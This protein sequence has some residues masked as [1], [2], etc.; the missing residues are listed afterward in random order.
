[1][2]TYDT[3]Q[4]SQI[5][6][7]TSSHG[8]DRICGVSI[9]RVKQAIADTLKSAKRQ[10]LAGMPLVGFI[11]PDPSSP[12]FSIR[13]ITELEGNT[14]LRN[15]SEVISSWFP[16]GT[17][18]CPSAMHCVPFSME[19]IPSRR[20]FFWE[21]SASIENQESRRFL[22][23]HAAT[24]QQEV[25]LALKRP[26]FAPHLITTRELS[27]E[28]HALRLRQELIRK[29]INDKRHSPPELLDELHYFLLS[30]NTS[31]KELRTT[32]HLL[33]LVRSHY[34]LRQRQA[35]LPPH[36]PE[37]KKV[38][39]RLF[40]SELH[41]PFG[42]RRVL[43]LVISVNSLLPHE[44]F[45]DRHILTACQRCLASLE[46]IPNSFYC[47]R[48]SENSYHAL[49]VEV[50]KQNGSWFTLRELKTL[51]RDLEKRFSSSIEQVVN[52]IDIPQN[53][54]DTIRS[55]LLLSQQLRSFKDPPQVMIQF[56]GQ[57]DQ[58][59]EFQVLLMRFLKE[60][61]PEI[62]VI[63]KLPEMIRII[64]LRASVVGKLRNKYTKQALTLLARC[65]KGPFHRHDRSIDFLKAREFVVNC[66]EATLGKVR[67][68][69]GGLFLQQHELLEGIRPLLMDHE[70]KELF[71]VEELFHSI[72]PSIM[73]SVV[74]PEHILTIFRQ[75][76][77][78]RNNLKKGTN[79]YFV[80]EE[81]AKGAFIGFISPE[82]FAIE[83]ILQVRSILQISESDLAVCQCISEGQS[84]SFVVCLS[85]DRRLQT[86]LVEWVRNTLDERKKQSRAPRSLRIS[87]PNISFPLDPRIGPDNSSGSVIKML[88]EGLYRLDPT[89]KPSLAIAE[90]VTVSED[91]KTYTFFLRPTYWSNGKPVT[92]H[93]FEYGWKKFNTPSFVT[94]Y[95]FLFHPIK[96]AKQVKNGELPIEALGVR[97]VSDHILVV[98]LEKPAHYFLELCCHWVYS[99]LCKGLDEKHPGWAYFGSKYHISNG[100]FKLTKSA[101]KNLQLVKN[102]W[103]WD[104][105]H[106][107]LDRID[108]SI[109]E[110]SLHALRMFEQ[111]DLDWIGEPLCETPFDLIKRKDPRMH[112]LSLPAV[113]WLVI[114]VLRPPFCSLKVRHAFSCALDRAKMVKE[115]IGGDESPSH[116]ILPKMLSLL[117]DHE[118]LQYNQDHAKVLFREGLEEQ[119]LQRDS[120]RPIRIVIADKEPQRSITL[121]A[122]KSW[123]E[124]FQIS[125]QVEFA[126]DRKFFDAISESSYDILSSV[127]T[128]WFQD[129]LYTFHPLKNRTCKINASR[130]SNNDF[131]SLIEQAETFPN[132]RNNYLRKAEQL[133]MQEMPI[134]PVFDY[135]LR[136]MKNESLSNVY[137]HRIGNVDFR[138]TTF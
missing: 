23:D 25:L 10:L 58:T 9:D 114:N 115:C 7:P 60:G 54:E 35:S 61:E 11:P 15:L 90:H 4:L 127:W 94:L 132:Q 69:N 138:W 95:D 128:S 118:I 81:Y 100:P 105:E 49:Y 126:R 55:I 47:Y 64:P 27:Q 66:I 59:I 12:T 112:S 32:D 91:N 62:P 98:E 109:V 52:R 96:N 123:E 28:P 87:L 79:T 37:E 2:G 41:F 38:L 107:S 130:W 57:S 51:K 40:P 83:E 29:V 8:I 16:L 89:G 1:M 70:L 3:P 136:Y 5:I 72:T 73:K 93:D 19:A 67:D 135:T 20:F 97:A 122:I 116:S 22:Q 63:P 131:T 65:S 110:N 102:N 103:Y 46:L 75:L 56:R 68:L 50:E 24:L 30:V 43:S 113:H 86:S 111:G 108:I 71:L 77:T 14:A 99:P 134:I 80:V 104:K 74:G 84:Y 34:W 13:L 45:D 120:L 21:M 121:A 106:V 48:Y 33:R 17:V 6:L 78:I 18:L 119:G 88:Y 125:F 129:P 36:S 117:E 82:S 137:V 101:N 53:E 26:G 133:V 44:Q 39:F 124:T 92:A 42:Q 85:R 76:V 31:F